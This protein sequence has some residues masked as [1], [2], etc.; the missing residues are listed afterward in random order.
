MKQNPTGQDGQ[1]YLIWH[2]RETLSFVHNTR[3]QFT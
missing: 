2:Q 3:L 1:Q